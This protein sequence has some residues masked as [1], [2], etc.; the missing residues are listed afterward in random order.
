[1]ENISQVDSFS[2]CDPLWAPAPVQNISGD[3]DD[4]IFDGEDWHC[5]ER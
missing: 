3:V 5:S 1:M 4:M 2:A